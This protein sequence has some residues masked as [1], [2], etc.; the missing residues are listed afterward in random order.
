MDTT[1]ASTQ[2][3][4]HLLQIPNWQDLPLGMAAQRIQRGAF[5][6]AYAKWGDDA[7]TLVNSVGPTVT[8]MVQA[9]FTQ[10]LST[11]GAFG[12]DGQAGGGSIS[13]PP[14]FA[15][16]PNTPT[17]IVVA[18]NWALAQ[19]GTPYAFGGDCTDSHSG[20]PAHE[21]DCSSLTMMAYKTAATTI[22]RTAAEQSR[23]GTPVH[24]PAQLLPGDLLFIPGSD[25][26]ANAPGHVGLY[27]GQGLLVQSPHTGGHVK[28]TRLSAWISD[29]VG[30]RRIVN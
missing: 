4:N 24:S 21:C 5:P 18:I 13:L 8:G 11:C 23:A 3:Y 7:I 19:L 30:M 20:N 15:L 14:G 6:D 9:D 16:P 10:W 17:A 2:F 22:P 28:I 29:L 27:I 25:G 1:Y 12:G 26:T